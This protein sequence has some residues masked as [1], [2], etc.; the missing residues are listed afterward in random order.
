MAMVPNGFFDRDPGKIAGTSP[1]H[2]GSLGSPLRE[3]F[4][5]PIS[6]LDELYLSRRSLLLFMG[7]GRVTALL[8][9]QSPVFNSMNPFHTWTN[10]IPAI[11]Q[12]KKVHVGS[13]SSFLLKAV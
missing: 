12:Q 2:F 7:H 4:L 9:S 11:P 8:W 10:H 13:D 5:V 1:E 3:I 6:L